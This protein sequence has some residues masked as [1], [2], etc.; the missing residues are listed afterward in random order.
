MKNL[1]FLKISPL[2]VVAISFCVVGIGLFGYFYYLDYQE[3]QLIRESNFITK[4]AQKILTASHATNNLIKNTTHLPF[5]LSV[6][7]DTFDTH[8]IISYKEIIRL[9]WIPFLVIGSY[10][11]VHARDGIES[12]VNN[13][14]S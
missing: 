5:K 13:N 14:Y 4:S 2:I 3:E 11:L 12:A 6:I 1:V 8:H 7:G 10:L 9:V